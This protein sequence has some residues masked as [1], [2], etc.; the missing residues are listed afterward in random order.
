MTLTG[1]RIAAAPVP[2]IIA[3]R[4]GTESGSAPVARSSVWAAST[5]LNLN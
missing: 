5:L 3:P 4:G 2:L 1:V